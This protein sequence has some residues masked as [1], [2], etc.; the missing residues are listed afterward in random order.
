LD[1]LDESADVWD[2]GAEVAAT[3][4]Y[5]V[6]PQ[7]IDSMVPDAIEFPQPVAGMPMAP[8]DP[9]HANLSAEELFRNAVGASYWAGYWTALY[10]VCLIWFSQCGQL[11]S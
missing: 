7:P 4:S 10:Q 11:N 1:G 8:P 5:A 9:S 6:D 2:A 3:G